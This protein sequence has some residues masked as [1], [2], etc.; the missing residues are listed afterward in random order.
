[1]GAAGANTGGNSL[2]G[3]YA[4]L[5]PSAAKAVVTLAAFLSQMLAFVHTQSSDKA[6][7][8]QQQ[9]LEVPFGDIVLTIQGA[10][11]SVDT[12]LTNESGARAN[13][14]QVTIVLSLGIAQA[15]SGLNT[16]V[17]QN[18]AFNASVNDPTQRIDTGD[19]VGVNQGL[20]IICQRRNADD[21]K[22][23]VPPPNPDPIPPIVDNPDAPATF[24]PE[25]TSPVQQP[26][27][28]VINGP[29]VV[30]APVA[31]P[32][33]VVPA[34]RVTPVP[35]R[36]GQLPATGIGVDDTLILATLLAV[37]GSAL[38]LARR[39]RRVPPQARPQ[40]NLSLGELPHPE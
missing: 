40:A 18:N 28:L 12:S 14:R 39:R 16:A 15:N 21:I 34:V 13:V 32:V 3:R 30:D 5:D 22:C 38:V 27:G 31:V 37:I 10:L 6:Q 36:G 26:N 23:L 35:T 9:G 17:N 25:A 24:I 19:A 8:L 7:A 2:G 33:V 11:Q 29:A 1:M 20:V 4:N